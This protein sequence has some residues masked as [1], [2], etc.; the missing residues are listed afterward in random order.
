MSG[1]CIV[2][3]LQKLRDLREKLCSNEKNWK[4]AFEARDWIVDQLKT[5]LSMADSSVHTKDDIRERLADIL[6]V[7]EESDGD[8]DDRGK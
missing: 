2:D 7:F 4:E 8:C 1:N 5:L 6:C 3:R